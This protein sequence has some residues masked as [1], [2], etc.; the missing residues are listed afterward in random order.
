[1][2]I[3]HRADL[4]RIEMRDCNVRC[5]TCREG[6]WIDDA[7]I[8]E[9]GGYYVCEPCFTK[10]TCT[11]CGRSTC[12]KFM[13]TIGEDN[14]CTECSISCDECSE[15]LYEVDAV[16][17]TGCNNVVCSKCS[18][19]EES[20]DHCTSCIHRMKFYRAMKRRC[21]RKEERVKKAIE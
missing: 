12:A 20:G 17:C 19:H 15:V 3:P 9:I 13:R 5:T 14:V 2:E 16:P 4:V 21:Q 18:T 6:I 11:Y 7:M 8:C 1:M 10:S